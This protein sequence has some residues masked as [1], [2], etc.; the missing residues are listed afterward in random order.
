MRAQNFVYNRPYFSLIL[1]ER[2]R[3]DF[4]LNPT[5]SLGTMRYDRHFPGVRT[6]RLTLDPVGDPGG[7]YYPAL[8]PD[9]TKMAYVIQFTG[10]LEIAVMELKSGK[11]E[12]LTC[13][14]LAHE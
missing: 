3:A 10:S 14:S 4:V 5:G 11:R 13:F 12:Q 6:Q 1:R 7:D 8:S 9:G 2:G